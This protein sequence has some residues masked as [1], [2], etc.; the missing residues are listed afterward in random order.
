MNK[1]FKLKFALSIT[2]LVL[3]I[4]SCNNT[5]KKIMSNYTVEKTEDTPTGFIVYVTISEK[6]AENLKQVAKMIVDEQCDKYSYPTIRV[7]ISTPSHP[8]PDDNIGILGKVCKE[9]RYFGGLSDGL[10]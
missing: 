7:V 4:I 1:H 2:I 5:N 9:D 6:D 8:F 10:K 3:S